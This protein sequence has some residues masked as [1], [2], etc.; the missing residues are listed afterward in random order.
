M[1]WVFGFDMFS[2]K[3]KRNRRGCDGAAAEDIKEN[4]PEKLQ[5][6]DH[7]RIP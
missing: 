3:L 7:R 4:E 1:F 5:A 2:D 6:D